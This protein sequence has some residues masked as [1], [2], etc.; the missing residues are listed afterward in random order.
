MPAHLLGSL[1]TRT[2]FPQTV[3][4]EPK[5]NEE[6]VFPA[7]VHKEA[8]T[9]EF[10]CSDLCRATS[11]RCPPRKF[12]SGPNSRALEERTVPSGSDSVTPI[13]LA[14]VTQ[15]AIIA[16]QILLNANKL[17]MTV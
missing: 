6:A 14:V 3:G 15:E 11:D 7:R 8:K 4:R 17:V 13:V 12:H 5:E 10:A 1:G 9:K 16:D 2:A